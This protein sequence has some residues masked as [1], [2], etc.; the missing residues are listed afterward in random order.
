[1]RSKKSEAY[2][3][4]RDRFTAISNRNNANTITSSDILPRAKTKKNI[5]KSKT[6]CSLNKIS[7]FFQTIPI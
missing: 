3:A 4:K 6:M 7:N 2:Q 5:T 1:M